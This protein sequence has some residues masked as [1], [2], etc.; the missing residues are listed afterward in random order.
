MNRERALRVA[1]HPLASSAKRIRRLA[2]ERGLPVGRTAQMRRLLRAA[3][4][5]PS[6]ALVIGHPG[7]V[8]QA[9]RSAH[10]DVVGSSPYDVF[11]NVVSDARGGDSLP[12]RWDCV[13]VTDLGPAPE[14]RLAAAAGACRSGGVV[15]ALS[16]AH[17]GPARIP[18]V[19]VEH[20]RRTKDMHLVVGRIQS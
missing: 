12:R 16:S 19:H 4:G 14:E 7:A 20:T 2:L 3:L 17:D 11:V 15:A 18:D 13:I 1:R 8:R 10:L 5:E 6:R 9:L